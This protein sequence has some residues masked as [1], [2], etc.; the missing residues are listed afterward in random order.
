LWKK[1]NQIINDLCMPRYFIPSF[2]LLAIIAAPAFAKNNSPGEIE[3][4]RGGL[5]CR[6]VVG[7]HGQSC[8]ALCAK[9]EMAC[10]GVGATRRPP[11]V[12][13]DLIDDTISPFP[14]CRCCAL[15]RR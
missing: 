2:L 8:D 3:T 11:L 6:S 7:Q 10:T 1:T 5:V 15:E 12:C 4:A 9:V 14:V 13:G